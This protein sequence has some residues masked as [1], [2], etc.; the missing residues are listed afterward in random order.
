MGGEQ[1]VVGEP[2]EGLVHALG[3]LAGRGQEL[4][5]GAVGAFLLLALI[6]QQRAHDHALRPGERGC[7]GIAQA[8]T[9]VGVAFCAGRDGAD[10]QQHGDDHLGLRLR[11]LLA[12]PGEM[13]AG[14]M[15]RFVRQHP[16][17]LVRGF[18]LQQ[19]AMVHE[20]AAAVGDEGVKYRLIDD[21]DLDVLLLK[22]GDPQDRPGIVAQELLGLGVAEDR[23]ALLLLR[24]CWNRRKDERDRG[25]DGGEFPRFPEQR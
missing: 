11:Q 16:D 9:A 17:D 10:A 4:D 6:G 3:G 8:T 7:A 2:L 22:A 20:N 23:K 14:Q 13:A 12:Q 18:R 21:R 5:P 25:G 15:A 19:C 1:A 24:E